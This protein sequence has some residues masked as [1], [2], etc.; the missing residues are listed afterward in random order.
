MLAQGSCH[1]SALSPSQ[2]AIVSVIPDSQVSIAFLED[3]YGLREATQPDFFSEWT[4]GLGA[5]TELEKQYLDRVKTHF[6][7]FLKSLPLL[8]NSGKMV[9]LSPLLDMA[10]FYDDP[11]YIRSE[12]SVEIATEDEGEVIRGRIDVLVLKERFWILALEAK[13]SGF[14]VNVAMGQALAYVLA[15]PEVEQPTSAMVSNG[16]SFLFLKLTKAPQSQYANSRLFSLVNPGNDL[17]EVL[18]VMKC[19]G[20]V[21]MAESQ[22]D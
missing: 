19:I 13:R 9:V 22:S 3:R 17:Y 2:D 14:D 10:G 16:Q 21:V 4:Q 11:F 12:V 7:R 20:E 15:N 5:L 18:Q 1:R 8:E 6:K